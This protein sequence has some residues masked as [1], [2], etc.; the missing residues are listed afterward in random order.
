MDCLDCT[1]KVCRKQQRSCNKENINKNE[2]LI[3]YRD[4]TTPEVVE[5]AA[6]LVDNGRAGRLSRIQEIIEFASNMRYKRIGLAYCYGMENYA[7]KIQKIF[8][9]SGFTVVPVS[10]SIGGLTQDEVNEKSCIHKVSCNPIGQGHQLNTEQVDITLI[11]GIC[12]GHDMLLQKQLN[13]N[14]TTLVV[15]DRVF[16]HNPLQGVDELYETTSLTKL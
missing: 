6:N 4:K 2:T 1:D 16:H 10:C 14:F 12:L 7:L 3:Q 5:A 13:M 11:M 15:K 9:N 8:K